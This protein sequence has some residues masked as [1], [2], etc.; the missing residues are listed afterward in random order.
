[1]LWQGYNGGGWV[2]IASDGDVADSNKY[3]VS[4]NPSTGLYY[5]LHILNVGV[6]DVKKY[7]CEGIVNGAIQQFYI[8]LDL[9]GRC[10]R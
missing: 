3:S 8:N 4:T 2:N 7:R 1:M 5:I 6:S 10:I 9:L